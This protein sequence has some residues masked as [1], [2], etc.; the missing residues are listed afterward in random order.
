[1]AWPPAWSYLF[2]LFLHSLAKSFEEQELTSIEIEQIQIFL[3]ILIRWLPC[4]SCRYHALLYL[5]KKPFIF[6]TGKELSYQL[7]MFHN[8]V[9]E[10]T[11]KIQ[12]TQEEARLALEES[13]QRRKAFDFPNSF[14]DDYWLVLLWVAHSFTMN[15]DHPTEQEQQMMKEFLHSVCFVFPFRNHKCV[16]GQLAKQVLLDVLEHHINVTNRENVVK[17]INTMYNS[18]SLEFGVLY[19]TMEQTKKMFDNSLDPTQYPLYVRMIEAEQATHKKLI[20]LQNE[21]KAQPKTFELDSNYWM[22]VCIALSVVLGL[23]ILLNILYL[24]KSWMKQRQKIKFQSIS[25]S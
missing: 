3:N 8:D 22:N 24:V 5:N 16:N 11:N 13:L 14:P 9:N 19:R 12:L 15:P 25:Q 18:L 7:F 17:T 6:K 20:A 1:M 23:V 2:W 21:L 10:R 4:P